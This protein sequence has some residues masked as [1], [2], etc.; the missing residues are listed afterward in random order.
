[1]ILL[2][3]NRDRYSDGNNAVI[4]L[5]RTAS[6]PKTS[7][8]GDLL[9]KSLLDS[10]SKTR[11]FSTLTVSSTYSYCV[12]PFSWLMSISGTKILMPN[13]GRCSLW[14]RWSPSECHS[15]KRGST[16]INYQM[17]I[18]WSCNQQVIRE[19]RHLHC[20]IWKRKHTANDNK[21][22]LLAKNTLQKNLV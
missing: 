8:N 17:K 3:H 22:T 10:F 19:E 6:A 4:Y 18:I 11:L 12:G 16:G 9:S 13:G 21:V 7:L 5:D 15:W 20:T 14:L 1:M 2:N